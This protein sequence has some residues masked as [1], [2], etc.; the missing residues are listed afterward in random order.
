M[1]LEMRRSFS[2]PLWAICSVLL[3][4]GIGW[5]AV[6]FYV[7]REPNVINSVTSVILG[8]VAKAVFIG[9]TIGLFVRRVASEPVDGSQA[10]LEKCGIDA[11]YLQRR[12]IA[13]TILEEIRDPRTRNLRI[14]GIS[15]RDF[16]LEMGALHHVWTAIADRLR[17]EDKSN[18]PL[19]DRLKVHILLLDPHS[20]E[21]DF[22]FEAEEVALAQGLRQDVPMAV[23][24][25]QHLT[26]ELTESSASAVLQVRQYQHGSFG[27]Q[28]ITESFAILE[29]Y[30]YRDQRGDATIPAVRYKRSARSYEPI[31]H[32]YEL[33][34]KHAEPARMD[35]APAGVGQGLRESLLIGIYRQ[36][37]RALLGDRQRQVLRHSRGGDLI[38]IQALS[39]RFYMHPPMIESIEQATKDIGRGAKIRL[40][41]MNPTSRSA[42]LR[43]VADR[44]P[45]EEIGRVIHNWTWDN[46]RFSSLYIDVHSAIQAVKNLREADRDIELRLSAADLSCAMLLARDA[47]FIEQYAY[48]RSRNYGGGVVL[49]GEYSVFEYSRGHNGLTTSEERILES[50]FE[51]LWDS[52][53]ISAEEYLERVEARQEEAGFIREIEALLAQLDTRPSD[54]EISVVILA[55]GYGTRIAADLERLP[56]L[57]GRP[58][59]LL[60]VAG[61][62]ILE[63][64]LDSIKDLKEIKDI[65]IVT[66]EGYFEAF[67]SWWRNFPNRDL[68]KVI[69]D[70]TRSNE[71][72]RGAL[73]DLRFAIDREEIRGSVLAIGGDNFFEGDFQAII[74]KFL[75]SKR[76][77]I[78]VHDEGSIERV[79][80]RLGVVKVDNSGRIIDFEEKPDRP[81]TT[82]ASTLCYA[83]TQSDIRLLKGYVRE[84]P[85][86]DNTGDFIRHLVR[87]GHQLQAVRFTGRWHDIG[88][89]SEYQALD[90][91]LSKG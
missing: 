5:I 8:E 36:G 47:I 41:I 53:S 22:R 29:P 49:G 64:L 78:F 11:V 43:A 46:H 26:R 62:P 69:S 17:H 34:W 37:Q 74:D 45:I 21:G 80:G 44:T 61:K 88:S 42:I 50:A 87:A 30:T 40:L 15:L 55:A 83:L 38:S 67:H 32:S 75:N 35:Q 2:V 20:P 33:V 18:L 10:S 48:G 73:G 31:S 63:W 12:E 81:K 39:G 51:V 4:T 77:A 86:A 28:F 85:R 70:G 66:N 23:K 76:G 7:G 91:L 57:K 24:A 1:A 27:F 19:A 6:A 59:A 89:F 71:E 9:S 79:A 72:R 84:N 16:L 90:D 54:E 3:W 58:K 14:A 25:I 13:S 65:T 56:H 52:Y 60:P 68:I 82:L